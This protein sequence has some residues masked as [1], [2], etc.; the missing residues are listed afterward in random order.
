MSLTGSEPYGKKQSTQWY[1]HHPTYPF[2][3]GYGINHYRPPFKLETFSGWYSTPDAAI[4]SD[5]S[6]AF[7]PILEGKKECLDKSNPCYFDIAVPYNRTFCALYYCFGVC[8][9][10]LKRI[11]S[12]CFFNHP[13]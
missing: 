12:A 3:S 13:L 6:S 10:T 1:I 4:T 8:L 9:P 11:G 2:S 7:Y 5:S